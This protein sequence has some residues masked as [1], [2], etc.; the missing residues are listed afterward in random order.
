MLVRRWSL[1]SLDTLAP[2]SYF[3][4]LSTSGPSRPLDSGSGAGMRG[5]KEHSHASAHAKGEC[6]TC[7]IYD[8]IEGEGDR[9]SV[10]GGRCW[11]GV[12]GVGLRRV[13][14]GGLARSVRA[15]FMGG[16]VR[17]NRGLF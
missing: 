5:D 15:R 3:E 7:S 17:L 4:S 2:R 11:W 1:P 10:M 13:G 14:D 6:S 12:R 16:G 8:P 9:T